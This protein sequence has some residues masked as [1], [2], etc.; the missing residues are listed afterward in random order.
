MQHRRWVKAA[1]LCTVI[2][3][4]QWAGHH[5]EGQQL[6]TAHQ[7]SHSELQSKF[8]AVPTVG[9]LEEVPA[10]LT[11]YDATAEMLELETPQNLGYNNSNLY[12]QQEEHPQRPVSQPVSWLVIAGLQLH[13]SDVWLFGCSI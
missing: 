11:A 8:G 12:G 1:A 6:H 13:T 9:A 3:V 2:V 5:S 7:P 4:V 10:D